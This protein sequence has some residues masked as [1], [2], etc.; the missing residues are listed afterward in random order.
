MWGIKPSQM[1][2]EE[3]AV[4]TPC[5][6]LVTQHALC[7]LYTREVQTLWGEKKLA[8]KEDEEIAGHKIYLKNIWWNGYKLI[9]GEGDGCVASSML[10]TF[11]CG[12]RANEVYCRKA[13]VYCWI[14]LLFFCFFTDFSDL[15][16][17]LPS[18]QWFCLLSLFKIKSN[19]KNQIQS[20]IVISDI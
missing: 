10:Q 5:D 7:L 8:I 19:L 18:S 13:R 6:H 14:L 15:R 12:L 2:S 17:R 11:C 3:K 9:T 20:N 1:L 4:A 16:T